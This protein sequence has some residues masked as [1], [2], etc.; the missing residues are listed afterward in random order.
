MMPRMIAPNSIM[1]Q[2]GQHAGIEQVSQGQSQAVFS[3]SLFFNLD[4][5]LFVT[6]W[7]IT[8]FT[9]SMLEIF[10][11]AGICNKHCLERNPIWLKIQNA[12][13][14]VFNYLTSSY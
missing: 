1:A 10:K 2:G 11:L 7:Q 6:K 3:K 12:E 14:I 9:R 5:F 13:N 8:D 4:T